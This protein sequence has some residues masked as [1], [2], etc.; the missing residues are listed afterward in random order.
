MQDTLLSCSSSFAAATVVQAGAYRGLRQ[1]RPPA[2]TSC[3]TPYAFISGNPDLSIVKTA[4]D[5]A[6]LRGK[7]ELLIIVG[8]LV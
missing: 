4:I 1:A 7:F 5:A 2:N 8:G 6:E 3:T